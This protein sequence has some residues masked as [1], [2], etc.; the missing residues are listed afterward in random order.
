ALEQ[1]KKSFDLEPANPA[2]RYLLGQAYIGKGM[3]AEATALSES[4]LQSD[5]TNQLML[6]TAG[7]AYA[8]SG[9]RDK[10]EEVINR[11]K[12]MAKTKYVIS[13][14][15]TTIY[16]ALGDKDKAF[17]ELEKA[18]AERD[19]TLPLMKGDPLMDP[20]RDDP[21]FKDML[22]HLNLPE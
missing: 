2:A 18:F 6:H 17:A 14:F 11:F 13:Y 4:A 1:S 10:A 8:R 7:C 22:R 21:R 16:A 3:Y 15:V 20:L 12:E 19:W 5:P 9:R